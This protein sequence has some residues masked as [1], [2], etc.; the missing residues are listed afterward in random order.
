MGRILSG[1][2]ALPLVDLDDEVERVAQKSIREIFHDGGEEA[3]RDLESQCLGEVSSRPP[4]VVALGG[5]AILREQNRELIAKTGVCVWLVADAEV[6]AERIRSDASTA[7]RRPA[8]TDL[9][10]SAE[11][12]KLLA[13][14]RPLYQAAADHQIDT[15]GKNL[16]QISDEILNLLGADQLGD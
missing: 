2:L 4:A 13:D 9:P 6:L 10:E 3:F 1:S 14:R 7:D 15:A 16:Q 5:G 8:L 12:E 11:V